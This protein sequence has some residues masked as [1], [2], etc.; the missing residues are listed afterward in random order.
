[1]SRSMNVQ[2][3]ARVDV[4]ALKEAHPVQE[5]LAAYGVELRRQGRAAVGRCPFHAD[6]GRPNLH[7]WADTASW[8]CFRCCVGGD[9]LRFVELAEGLSFREAVQHLTGAPGSER[10]A[11][12]GSVRPKVACQNRAV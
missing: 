3:A 7:V 6:H 1:M 8:F 9:V 12:P 10:V 11:V 2:H 4:E 5:V